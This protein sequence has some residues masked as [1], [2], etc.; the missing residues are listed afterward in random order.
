MLCLPL[1]VCL[2]VCFNSLRYMHQDIGGH[3]STEML[4]HSVRLFVEHMPKFG[5][6]SG[7]HHMNFGYGMYV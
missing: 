3:L 2:C 4:D 6:V 5:Q 7:Y 1:L